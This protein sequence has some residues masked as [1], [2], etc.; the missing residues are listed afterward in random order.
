M[1]IIEENCGCIGDLILVGITASLCIVSIGV[2]PCPMR[3]T[4]VLQL[5][6][7]MSIIITTSVVPDDWCNKLIT[8][9]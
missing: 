5:S 9:Q 2:R 3:L 6:D 8:A 1:N 4:K 7:I